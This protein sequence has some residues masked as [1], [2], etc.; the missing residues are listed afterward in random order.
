MPELLHEEQLADLTVLPNGEAWIVGGIV[1]RSGVQED[2]AN[3]CLVGRYDGAAWRFDEDDGCGPLGR[4]WARAANDVWADGGDVVHWNGR[5]LTKNPKEKRGAIVGRHGRASGWRLAIGWG[6]GGTG[7]LVDARRPKTERKNVRDFWAFNADD[8]WAIG[9]DGALAHFDGQRWSHG[10]APIELRAVAARAADDVWAFG[11]Q[12]TLLHFDGHDWRSWRLP[13][14]DSAYPI[15]VAATASA[16]A[17]DVWVLTSAALWRFDGQ[18]WTTIA[19]KPKDREMF[20]LFAR[21]PNDVWVGAGVRL[22]HWN[23][24]A[25]ETF[26]LDFEPRLLWGNAR[27]LWAGMRLHR[28]D[29]SKMVIPPELA[30]PDGKGLTV[31]SAVA[32]PDALW[33][34]NWPTI[35]RVTGGRVETIRDLRALKSINGFWVSPS[36]EIWVT[37]AQG[38]SHG[39][40]STWTVEPGPGLGEITAI[41]GADG[42]VWM[43]G[44][45]GLL[46]RR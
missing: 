9:A 6:G 44:P 43:F 42:V 46:F 23:G 38:V 10:D 32:T 36:G 26:D 7:D 1:E 18:R 39:S 31:G 17:I 22:L 41:G 33:L 45:Q 35:S 5:Y 15:A 27:E 14:S 30:G 25:I 28:W 11:A 3:H 2:V 13:G 29:G 16:P 40:G 19:T 20:S 34:I 24:R 8:V 4:V 37:S 21:A 12:Q